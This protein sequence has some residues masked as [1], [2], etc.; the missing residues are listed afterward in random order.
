MTA[1]LTPVLATNILLAAAKKNGAELRYPL[2]LIRTIKHNGRLIALET[3]NGT[4]KADKLIL[5]TGADQNACQEFA[6]IHIPQRTT[7]GI[8]AVTSPMPKLLNR[9]ISAPGIHLHQRKDGRV[10]VGEQCGAPQNQAHF[11][12][13]KERPNKFPNKEFEE[14]HFYRMLAIGQHYVPKLENASLES[15]FIGWRPLPLDGHPVLGVTSQTK[16]T[17]I[18]IMHSGVSLAPIVGQLVAH[19]VSQETSIDRLDAYRPNREFVN[20]KR[21]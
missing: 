18:A 1:A 8:I 14:Q 16:D 13:L 19:E 6:N 10:V 17:Y 4:I 20:V 9:I 11:N 15:M 21:Y 7:A 5:A 12:R 3:N 2:S